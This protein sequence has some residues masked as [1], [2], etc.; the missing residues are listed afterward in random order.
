VGEVER[1]AVAIDGGALGQRT[2]DLKAVGVAL[3]VVTPSGRSISKVTPDRA[4]P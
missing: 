4:L 1:E 3:A 2:S